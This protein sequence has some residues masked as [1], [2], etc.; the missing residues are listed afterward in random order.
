MTSNFKA[1]RRLARIA[2][3]GGAVV[4]LVSAGPLAW[5]LGCF[6]G[7]G[8][9]VFGGAKWIDCNAEIMRREGTTRRAGA[10]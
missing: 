3:I 5:G 1:R 7:A 2:T 4:G 6:V 8:L 9:A 10:A